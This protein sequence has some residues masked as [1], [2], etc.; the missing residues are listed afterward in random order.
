ME[1]SFG[2]LKPDCLKRK[3]EKQVLDYIED[4]GLEI[5]AQKRVRLTEKQ[6]EAIWPTCKGMPFWDDMA[7]FSISG[8]CIVFLTE[9]KRAITRLN[10]LVGYWNPREAKKHTIRHKFGTSAMENII[11]SSLDEE[12]M[13]VE[14]E[15]FF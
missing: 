9:G 6:V 3:I 14:S 1:R 15:L 7:A 2:L 12:T 11:H 8:D 10:N 5:I 4:A 13:R